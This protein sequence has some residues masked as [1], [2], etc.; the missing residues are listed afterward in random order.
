MVDKTNKKQDIQDQEKTFRDF[1]NKL[2]SA[3]NYDNDL[4]RTDLFSRNTLRYTLTEF[5]DIIADEVKADSCTVQLT[6]YDSQE[7]LPDDK[8]RG[9]TL[10]L[11]KRINYAWKKLSPRCKKY[12]R[13][14]IQE[15]DDVKEQNN[16]RD[17]NLREFFFKQRKQV[18]ASTLV[19]PYWKYPKGGAQLVAT[20]KLKLGNE[21][22]PQ[23]STATVVPP[24][25]PILEEG[26][27][28]DWAYLI[29]SLGKGITSDIA[30]DKFARIRQ[31]PFSI[32]SARCLRKLGSADHIVWNNSEWRKSFKNYYGVP[33]RIHTSGEVI[34]ILKVENKQFNETV[35]GKLNTEILGI[36]FNEANKVKVLPQNTKNILELESRILR[37]LTRINKSN[38]QYRGVSLFALAYLVKDLQ[39]HPKD[40]KLPNP[41][42]EELVCIPYPYP[43]I[44]NKKVEELRQCISEKSIVQILT[45]TLDDEITLREFI[46][47]KTKLLDMYPKVKEF[48]KKVDILFKIVDYTKNIDPT[49]ELKDGL[50]KI[51]K[52]N[53]AIKVASF[54]GWFNQKPAKDGITLSHFYF[55]AT[56]T[57]DDNSGNG[58][59]SIF[60]YFMKP[61]TL[62]EMKALNKRFF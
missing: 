9:L 13:N 28:G 36:S 34:G 15:N 8:K 31:D 27:K 17:K 41:N 16:R 35:Q 7:A 22:S 25:S 5:C 6:L 11:D 52:K 61:P 42:I 55:R 18:M 60:L 54:E 44:N 62:C 50:E 47:G 57:L 43:K 56:I 45:K 29:A 59:K 26:K 38:L 24:W 49:K 37:L 19:F 12:L 32:R 58:E 39:S 3:Q 14:N 23:D 33:I 51:F 30:Q 40:K 2:L 46:S 1:A 48:Y 20:N 10:D 4:T 21:S 53:S